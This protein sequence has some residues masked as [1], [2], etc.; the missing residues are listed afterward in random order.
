MAIDRFGPRPFLLLVFLIL[1]TAP[2]VGQSVRVLSTQDGL[3]QSFVSGLVQDD[4]EFV[5]IGTRN[6]LAKFDGVRYRVFQHDRRD[7]SS[8]ASNVILGMKKDRNNRLWLEFESGQMDMLDMRSEK[9]TH[10][11]SGGV[12]QRT[13]RKIRGQRLAGRSI[14]Q[15][16]E[17][18]PRRGDSSLSTAPARQPDSIQGP[19]TAFPATRSADYSKTGPVRSGCLAKRGSAGS[20]RLKP[21]IITHYPTRRISIIFI[22]PKNASSRSTNVVTER[23]CGATAAFFISSTRKPKP[24]AASRCPAAPRNWGSNGSAPDPPWFF[25]VDK[26]Q[27]PKNTSSAL[28]RSIAMTTPTAW[29]PVGNALMYKPE[30]APLPAGGSFFRGLGRHQRRRHPPDRSDGALFPLE[31]ICPP[32]PRRSA[33]TGIRTVH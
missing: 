23:S 6:G 2:A 31:E 30:D 19:P 3:P 5:W 13:A 4:D 15:L 14:R 27:R 26:R 22:V 7:S 33:K 12:L 24:S 20:T 1:L 16:L 17:H 32:L 8:P 11:M 29:P 21:S 18:P 10:V 25:R 9:I 28:E